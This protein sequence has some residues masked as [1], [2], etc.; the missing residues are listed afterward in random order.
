MKL[1]IEM[2]GNEHGSLPCSVIDG[3]GPD[4]CRGPLRFQRETLA[5][6][7][8]AALLAFLENCTD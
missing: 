4:L 3:K 5:V 8:A 6:E 7:L 1:S 2:S